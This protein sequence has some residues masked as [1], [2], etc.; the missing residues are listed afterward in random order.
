M[1]PSADMVPT[2]P[3]MPSPNQPAYPTGQ[4][5]VNPLPTNTPYPPGNPTAPS[6]PTKADLAAGYSSPD[7]GRSQHFKFIII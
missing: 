4:G 2:Y 3:A 7:G 5:W 6:A 1:Y